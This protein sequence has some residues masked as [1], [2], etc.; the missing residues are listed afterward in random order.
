MREWE[1]RKELETMVWITFQEDY[2]RRKKGKGVDAVLSRL[3]NFHHESNLDL[4]KC[5]WRG[6]RYIK[7]TKDRGIE[8]NEVLE[9]MLKDR[10]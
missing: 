1:V 7:D 2:K 8:F 6:I 5:Q 3:L 4:F 9:E 10:H